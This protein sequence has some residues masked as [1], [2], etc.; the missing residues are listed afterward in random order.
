MDPDDLAKYDTALDVIL[1]RIE[2][3]LDRMPTQTFTSEGVVTTTMP[4]PSPMEGQLG[5][6]LVRRL[7]QILTARG[8]VF[9]YTLGASSLTLTRR[10]AAGET[11]GGTVEPSSGE[12]SGDQLGRNLQAGIFIDA[13]IGTLDIGLYD[14]WSR[15]EIIGAL[16]LVGGVVR[17]LQQIYGGD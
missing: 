17:A 12:A 5:S 8:F 13:L 2:G 11:I 14:G 3:V 6:H 15:S 1:S 7:G 4:L 16:A 10:V 9:G